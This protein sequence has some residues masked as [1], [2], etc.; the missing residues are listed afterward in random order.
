MNINEDVKEF[1]NKYASTWDDN[2]IVNEDII[3]KILDDANIKENSSVLDVATGTGVLIPFYLKRNVSKIIAIDLSDK[4]IDVARSKF[5]DKRIKFICDD[6]LN[7][8]DYKFDSIVV[9]N[10]FPHFKDGD[11]LIK[12]LSNM[13]NSGGRLVIAHGASRDKINDHHSGS[14]SNVSN[15]LMTSE[16]LKTIMFKYLNVENIIDNDLM[17]EVCGEKR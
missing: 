2:L 3:N 14:A 17:Y 11:S 10:A 12:H 9:Y 7:I 6:V 8:T 4:M 1:F 16:E 15:S 5:D 13:L